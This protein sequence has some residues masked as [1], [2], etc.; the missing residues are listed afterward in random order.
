[1]SVAAA[2]A[3]YRREMIMGFEARKSTLAALATTKESMTNGLTVTFAIGSSGG[4]TAVTRGVNG[5]IPYGNPSTTQVTATLV[6]KH[7]P[8]EMTG[9]NIFASQGDQK[10]NMQEASYAVI[11]RDQ[12]D[13]IITELNNATQDYGTGT[14]TL[15]N[16]MGAVAILGNNDVPTEEIDNMFGLLSPGAYAYLMQLNTFTSADYVDMK[17]LVGPT[18]KMLRWGGVNWVVS[19][20]VE[21]KGTN[22]EK[23]YVWHRS[24]L[25]Y[26][27]NMGEEKIYVGFDEKQGV[28]W[29]RAEIYHAAK[30]LQN[31]GIVKITHDGSAYVAS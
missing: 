1:M 24:A 29:T 28:S 17:P 10:K 8:F 14:L 26:A 15:A 3:T 25:G 19:S 9:F 30:I 12:D 7:A 27:V 4:A 5:Q 20:R 21:G 2:V 31:S 23:L 13:T 18:R 22:A 11:R 6:E 16:V